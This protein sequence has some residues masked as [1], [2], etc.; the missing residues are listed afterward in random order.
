MHSTNTTALPTTAQASPCRL[1]RPG[2][3]RSVPACLA[4]LILLA[5]LGACTATTA[6]PASG[7]GAP[8]NTTATAAPAGTTSTTTPAAPASPAAQAIPADAYHA[9]FAA[10]APVIDGAPDDPAWQSA[11]WAPIDQIWIGQ[12]TTP[13]D[14]TGHFRA[15]WTADRLYVL[16]RFRR[17][18]IRDQ[19]PSEQGSIWEYDCAEIFI[20]EDH[21][22]GNHQRTY[23]A[24]AYHMTTTGNAYDQGNRGSG[25]VKMNDN[26]SLKFAPSATEPDIYYWECELKV[27]DASYKWG[28]PNT[29]LQLYPGK[30]MGFLCAYNTNNGGDKRQNMF[31]SAF[32]PGQDKNTAWMTA[33]VFG[34]L[35]LDPPPA[36]TSPAP[37]D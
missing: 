27:F 30:V 23:N 11:A 17:Q 9:P 34:H 19:Y 20:D 26:I 15:V 7:A 8:A 25:W 5:S 32:I 2:F 35:V 4:G 16:M 14:Y 21:S 3:P 13:E 12:P 29:P 28:K 18:M 37:A 6:A 31:G 33:D 10:S 24:F 36:G 22:H 1:A